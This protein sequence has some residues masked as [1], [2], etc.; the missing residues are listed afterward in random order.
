M[1]LCVIGF[2]L[3]VSESIEGKIV[4]APFGFCVISNLFIY[5]SGGQLIRDKSENVADN[6]YTLD[7]D[8]V[9]IIAR[10]QRPAI[11]KSGIYEASLPTFA[12]ILSSAG[13][14]MT[15]LQSFI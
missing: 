15:V 14:M 1:Q 11:I 3:V 8:S 13:S 2:H 10:A 12:A 5:A 6:L 7:K 9:I 4:L